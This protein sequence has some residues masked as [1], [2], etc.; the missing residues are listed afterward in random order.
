MGELGIDMAR[1]PDA[2]HFA[3]W[4]TLSPAC[5]ITGGKAKN[6]HRP[7]TA[8]RVAEILRMAAMNAGRTQTALG[9][10]Y[11][12]LAVRVGK[13]KAVVA[14]AAKMARVVYLMMRNVMSYK[15]SGYAAYEER[16]RE[17]VI[18]NLERRAK[19]LGLRLLP[20]L[21][22]DESALAAEVC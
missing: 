15:E 6:A 16:Y 13:A 22:P 11:R 4:T 18:R 19:T 17:R 9:A 10:F 12:R 14:T 20:A 7:A 1:W 5:R 21:Q 8:H 3:S 2:D